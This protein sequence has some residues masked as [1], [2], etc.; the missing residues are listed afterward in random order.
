MRVILAK[1]ILMLAA[2]GVTLGLVLGDLAEAAAY[3]RCGT[4]VVIH[5][6][7][8]SITRA[9]TV[10]DS[11]GRAVVIHPRVYYGPAGVRGQARRVSR[12]TARRVS[13]RR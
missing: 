7:P 5:V 9:V 2:A 3:Y 12:R 10:C 6:D 13:R 4:T 1:P 11:V 8:Y